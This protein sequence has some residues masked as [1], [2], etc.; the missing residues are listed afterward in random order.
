LGMTQQRGG[1]GQSISF[2][3]QA[4]MR[5][6]DE[7]VD[8]QTRKDRKLTTPYLSAAQTFWKGP[9]Q[10]LGEPRG[11]RLERAAGARIDVVSIHQ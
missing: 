11:G 9:R 3:P 2:F 5:M 7:A 1:W 8:C 6:S 4:R 10:V